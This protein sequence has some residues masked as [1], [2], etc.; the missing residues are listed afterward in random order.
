MLVGL[1][2]Q[3]QQ[4]LLLAA[5]IVDHGGGG[6]PRLHGDLVQRG[7]RKTVALEQL[8]RRLG[9]HLPALFLLPFSESAHVAS[10]D[11][12]QWR[13]AYG[14]LFLPTNIFFTKIFLDDK[15]FPVQRCDERTHLPFALEIRHVRRIRFDPQYPRLPS[16]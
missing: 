15:T 5:E 14:Y 12:C 9:N 2:E 10:V 8:E 13:S 3:G 11:R 6:N 1:L 4:N 7:S 16:L